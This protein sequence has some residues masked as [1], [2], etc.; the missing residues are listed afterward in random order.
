M[1]KPIENAINHKISEALNPLYLKVLNESPNHHVPEGAETHFKVIVVSE[2]FS[3]VSLVKRHQSVYML[4]SDEMEQGLHALSLH[5]FSPEEWEKK[6]HN[7]SLESPP[8]R[9]GK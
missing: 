8:C 6:Q 9:G 5:T 1:L 3:K 7:I 2:I 4:L